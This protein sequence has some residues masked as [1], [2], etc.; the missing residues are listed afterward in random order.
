MPDIEQLL[1]LAARDPR[2]PTDLAAVAHR[3]R[4]LVR[5]RRAGQTA[6]AVVAVLAIVVPGVVL[7]GGDKQ[8]LQPTDRVPTP[9]PSAGASAA[10]TPKGASGAPAPS[11][12]AAG[13]LPPAAIGV[14]PEP[15]PT[16]STAPADPTGAP[17]ASPTP[18]ARPSGGSYP[19][20]PS[21][22]VNTEG[23][24]PDQSRSCRFTATAAGG[25]GTRQQGGVNAGQPARLTVEVTRDGVTQHNPGDR[26]GCADAVVAPGD[27]V[28]VTIVQGD[29]G[30]GVTHGGA[31]DVWDCARHGS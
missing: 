28:V 21:C 26:G 8:V 10:P 2:T 18:T 29:L 17:S 31:G 12:V 5:R 16:P 27:Q 4:V 13:S 30:Y 24:L 11:G 1:R 9:T 3:G 6:V 7:A 14:P 19:S 20:A 22:T 23:L 25:W 15:D